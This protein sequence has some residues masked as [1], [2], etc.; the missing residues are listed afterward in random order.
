MSSDI[1]NPIKQVFV[2][3]FNIEFLQH[4]KIFL[5]ERS[6]GMMFLLIADVVNDG[7]QLGMR[8]GEGTISFLPS[9]FAFH[10]FL[11]CDEAGRIR[12]NVP[13]QIRDRFVRSQA[14]EN[15]NMVGHSIDGKELLPFVRN[16]TCCVPMQF[17]FVFLW[18][19]VL[20]SLDCKYDMNIYLRERVCHKPSLS[21]VP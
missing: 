8:V 2:I 18:N 3:M 21:M 6:L 10:P 16:D 13:N 9:K 5:L 17:F 15:M 12:F 1:F 11:L 14:N 7:C 19:Q 4:L 20:S